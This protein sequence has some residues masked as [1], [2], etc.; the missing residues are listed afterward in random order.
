[1][2]DL[3]DDDQGAEVKALVFGPK[4]YQYSD[5]ATLTVTPDVTTPS[6][7]GASAHKSMSIFHL[8]FSENMDEE[9]LAETSNYTIEGLTVESAEASG[10]TSVKITTSTQALDTV[11][12]IAFDVAD[13]SN[14]KLS[15]STSVTTF[16]E[17]NGYADIEYYDGIDGTALSI[18]YDDPEFLAGNFSSN[19]HIPETN[20]RLSFGGWDNA[21]ADNYGAKM[22]GWIIAPE[23][24][25]Y[26]F[27][28]HSERLLGGPML[29]C[30]MM[31]I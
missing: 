29:L 2:S 23:T 16:K 8:T 5:T 18:L 15:G 24:G 22:S 20:T 9:S 1:L 6:L 28:F 30:L 19:I 3:S 26:R 4:S 25:E 7:T 21:R 27:F 14:N 12:Q 31:I 11:Y 13:I 10:P 17:I